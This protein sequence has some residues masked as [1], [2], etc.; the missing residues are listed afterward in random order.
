MAAATCVILVFAF[1]PGAIAHSSSFIRPQVVLQND[2]LLKEPRDYYRQVLANDEDM[3]YTGELKLGGQTIRGIIDTGSFEIVVFGKHCNSTDCLLA[4]EFSK[5]YDTTQSASYNGSSLKQTLSYGSGDVYTQLGYDTVNLG[6]HDVNNVYFWEVLKAQMP[7]MQ[8]AE[9]QAIIGVG[10]PLTKDVWAAK[11]AEQAIETEKVYANATDEMTKPLMDKIESAKEIAKESKN[12]KTILEQFDTTLYSVCLQ[13]QQGAEGYFIWNDHDPADFPEIFDKMA[14][15]DPDTWSPSLK[16]AVLKGGK[17][18]SEDKLGCSESECTALLD[19]GT[20]LLAVPYDVFTRLDQVL[21]GIPNV[22]EDINK[23]PDLVFELGGKTHTLP[24]SSY[25]GEVY[26]DYSAELAPYVPHWRNSTGRGLQLTEQGANAG[27]QLLLMSSFEQNMWILGMP[28]F[29]A[30]YTTYDLGS[31][32]NSTAEE[33]S[34]YTA[35]TD[36]KCTHP[37]RVTPSDLAA[38]TSLQRNQPMRRIDAS[39][40]QVSGKGWDFLYKNS[41][42]GIDSL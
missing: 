9:F 26:G 27:C 6:P 10:P 24:P 4:K 18:S 8:T 22:C 31:N 40:V 37:A 12:M 7:L 2:D 11:T 20:S 25:I 5:F 23:L 42:K 41:K 15:A 1:F 14:V 33:R 19:S 28:F 32:P 3:S 38:A 29:R 17:T 34:I 16:G 36:D 39:K 21:S 13:P 30:Y 35:V